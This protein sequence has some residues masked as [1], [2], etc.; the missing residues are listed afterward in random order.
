MEEPSQTTPS[1]PSTHDDAKSENAQQQQQP[2]L[3]GTQQ[4]EILVSWDENDP[5]HPHSMSRARRWLITVIVSLGSI[6]V[7]CTSSMYV[8]IYGQ[9]TEEFHCSTL[10]ATV[11]L[12]T[13]VFGLGVGPLV[14]APLSE[15]YGRRIIYIVSFAVFSLWLIPCA[16]AQNIETMIIVRFFAGLA[17]SAFL[18]VAG[19]TVGDMFPRQE[20]GAPM[21][22]YTASPFVGPELGPLVGGFINQYTNWRW[23]F[24][25][26]LIWAGAQLVALVFLVPETYHPVLL[27]RKAMKLRASTGNDAYIAPMEKKKRSITQTILQSVYRPMQMLTLEPMCL[28]LCIYSSLLLG[29]L[30]LFFGAFG[31][32]FRDVYGFQLWQVGASFL[33]ILVGML[34][35]MATD[36]FWKW[37]YQ[38]L[39][40]NHRKALEERG[41]EEEKPASMPEW[42]L[43]PA[44]G[45]APLV[46]IGIFIFAWTTYPHVH[47]IAPIVGSAVFGIGNLLVFSGIFTFLVD[48]YPLYAASALAANSFARSSF[49]G[50]FPLFGHSM[51]SRLGY[52]WASTLLAFLTLLMLPFPY[53]FFR[54][55]KQI[56]KRSRFA[57]SLS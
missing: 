55:G 40:R 42:R 3:I 14:L 32:I 15:F 24:Y 4:D 41:A 36:P 2:P 52:N 13:Y 19:G 18:S 17:G 48:A 45:G 53:I 6:C 50:A 46:T 22:F 43:P 10:V 33:G 57:T 8:M 30:Y 34:V 1:V 47:W 28:N 35:A 49:A 11:G 12:S 31:E 21:M 56:R 26:L 20:L 38:R 29:I 5:M 54:Y 37:N 25:V 44:I 7:T 16:V 9:I 51:Y 27:K 39:E 23:T